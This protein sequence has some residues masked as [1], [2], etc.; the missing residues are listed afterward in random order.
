MPSKHSLSRTHTQ[1]LTDHRQQESG[2]ANLHIQTKYHSRKSTHIQTDTNMR[3]KDAMTKIF[4]H[5][6][7][8]TFTTN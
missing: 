4:R 3:V 2:E 7:K 5:Q 6:N 1:L 8:T